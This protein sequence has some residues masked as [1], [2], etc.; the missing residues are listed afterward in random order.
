MK[1]N[2][3]VMELPEELLEDLEACGCACKGNGGSGSG[4]TSGSG[5]QVFIVEFG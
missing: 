4:S 2:S 1:D 5:S 3:Q